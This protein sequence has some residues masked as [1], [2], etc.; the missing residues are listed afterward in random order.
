MTTPRI[1]ENTFYEVLREMPDGM[2]IAMGNQEDGDPGD[3]DSWAVVVTKLSAK[4]LD[5]VARREPDKIFIVTQ[6]NRPNAGEFVQAL[7]HTLYP[8]QTES[9]DSFGIIFFRWLMMYNIVSIPREDL[10]K[11]QL[12]ANGFS[13]SVTEALPVSVGAPREEWER[14]FATKI[15][16]MECVRFP[17]S[18][19]NVRSLESK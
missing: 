7:E 19:P 13:L 5:G 16:G 18:G 12:I 11:V 14:E 1:D 10:P 17:M 6:L 15:M 2:G 9:N 8:P 4:E 3:P